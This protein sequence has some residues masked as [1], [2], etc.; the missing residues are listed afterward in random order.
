MHQ[1]VEQMMHKTKKSLSNVIDDLK[2]SKMEEANNNI[3][4]NENSNNNS[5]T[6]SPQQSIETTPGG[7]DT[8]GD[9][10]CNLQ[11][12]QRI[13]ANFTAL[14]ETT[15]EELADETEEDVESNCVPSDLE[16]ARDERKSSPESSPSNHSEEMMRQFDNID[17]VDC[18]KRPPRLLAKLLGGE[19]AQQQQQLNSLFT[20]L[21]GNNNSNNSSF[22]DQF[23]SISQSTMPVANISS[24]ASVRST[25]RV[26]KTNVYQGLYPIAEVKQYFKK[27]TID[28]ET[29]YTC[30]WPKCTF[31]TRKYSQHI[32]RHI[33]LKHIGI[34][35]L[36]CCEPM[37]SK[38]FKRPESL[39]QHQK[40]HICGFG[41]D[42]ERVR[43]PTNVCGAKNINRHFKRIRDNDIYI[44]QCQFGGCSFATSNSGSIRRHVHNQHVCPNSTSANV[45]ADVNITGEDEDEDDDNDNNTN[46]NNINV[47]LQLLQLRGQ[48][49]Q[50]QSVNDG[51]LPFYPE[52]QL[53]ESK[54]PY[55]PSSGKEEESNKVSLDQKYK[56]IAL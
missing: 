46:N 36:K 5:N 41:I 14:N 22:I 4:N 18:Q 45:M 42:N 21:A 31:A 37:C 20:Q 32:S 1:Q 25:K 53:V 29:R 44:Y 28:N 40:N 52:V 30:L 2:E 24:N 27:E 48:Q 51:Q 10:V 55:L 6:N 17:N 38:I 35:E 26:G 15:D 47:A 23:S 8:T 13:I 34:K 16:Y 43:D 54:E 12:V 49:Q 39:V 3:K 7:A 19:R 50:Q 56:F 11:V 33:H 9:E